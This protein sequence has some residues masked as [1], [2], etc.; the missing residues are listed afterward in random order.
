VAL[1]TH[2]TTLVGGPLAHMSGIS[3]LNIFQI[4]G[5]DYLYTASNADGG[6]NSFAL[7]EGAAAAYVNQI[8]YSINRGTLGLRAVDTLQV[9]GQDILLPSGRFDDRTAIHKLGSDGGFDGLQILG[10][11]PTEIGGFTQ[12]IGIQIQGKTFMVASQYN[13]PGFRSFRLRDDLTLEHKK[14]FDDNANEFIG[15]VTS[16]AYAQVAGRSYFFAAS[17]TDAGVSSYWMGKWG[18]IK[19]RDSFGPTDGPGFSVPNVLETAVVDGTMYLLLGA[20]GTSSITVLRVNQFGGLFVEDHVLDTTDTRFQGV[21]DIETFVFGGR[22]FILAGGSDDGLTLFELAPGGN[23]FEI[24]SIAD[25]LNTTLQNVS[26]IVATV[27][28]SEIQVFV[29]GEAEQGVTQFTLDLGNLGATILGNDNANTLNGTAADDLI[30]GF[31]LADQLN[32]LAGDD[33]LVDGAG[34]DIMT[35]GAGA[36]V[37]V[38]VSDGRKDTV[39]DFVLGEDRLD[40]SGYTSIYHYSSLTI[41]SQTYGA[42]LNFGSERIRLETADGSSL[43]FDDFSQDDFIF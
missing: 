18:N 36:D 3:D 10:S 39:T 26:S 22:T 24:T 21:A 9:N 15:D 29:A 17:A 28:G 42:N 7:S 14:H 32:G 35:G 23:L 38:F 37:F 33:R 1:F 11:S 30:M 25:Q 19:Y 43:S 13:Q 27:I 41:T 20:F 5:V 31:D 40:L 34:A 6:M 2:V 12:S 8:G 4:G 16:L